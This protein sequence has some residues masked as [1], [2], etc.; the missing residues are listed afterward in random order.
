MPGGGGDEEEEEILQALETPGRLETPVKKFKLTEVRSAI[1][2]LRSNK[3]PAH[4]LITGR[5]LKELPDIK[6]RAITQIFKCLQNR[7][8][9][10]PM[11]G[12]PN[13]HIPEAWE[14]S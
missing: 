1:K 9:P 7:V 13:Y 3:A 4:E 12:F 14:T 5:I 2:Q 10:G 6:I 8:L 11:E